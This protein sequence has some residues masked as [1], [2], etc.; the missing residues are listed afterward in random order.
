[1]LKTTFKKEDSKRLVYRDYQNFSND[2]FQADLEQNL[3][4]CNKNYESFE[5]IFIKVLNRHA[6]IKTKFLR[7]NQKPHV[8]KNLRKAIMKRSKLKS[9]ANRTKQ[10]ND[11]ATF[12]K[13]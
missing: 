11:V 6:P 13:Q 10:I 1:M 3:P 5:N 8:D 12:K 4:N 7:G 2:I 9:K